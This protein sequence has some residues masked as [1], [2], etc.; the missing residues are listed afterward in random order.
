MF[1]KERDYTNFLIGEKKVEKITYID[2]ETGKTEE[3]NV[4]GV[5]IE[6]GRIAHTDLVADFI[7][8]DEK[9]QLLVNNQME[10]KT[11]GMFA[12]G[13]VTNASDFKQIPVAIGQATVA[14]LTAYK[15]LQSKD[16]SMTAATYY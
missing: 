9:L 13:D 3:I 12:A 16:S 10:T 11:P 8:R 6:I 1:I 2:N 14:A 4:E 7:D 5:F 15:Y